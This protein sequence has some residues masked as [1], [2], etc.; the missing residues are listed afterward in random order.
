MLAACALSLWGAAAGAATA[1][2]NVRAV[3]R[4]RASVAVVDCADSLVLTEED[5]RQGWVRSPGPMTVVV[6]ANHSDGIGLELLPVLEEIACA[7]VS[8]PGVTWMGGPGVGRV[9]LPTAPGE[10]RIPLHFRFALGSDV[11]PGPHRWPVQI[12]V[13]P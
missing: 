3:V 12:S 5:I 6:R 13:T 2:L 8:G 7:E 1:S 9:Q 11:R 10:Q 4:H